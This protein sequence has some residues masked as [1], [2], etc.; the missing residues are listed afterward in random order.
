MILEFSPTIIS[1][2]LAG[3]VGSAI[4]GQIGTMKVTEQ[5]DALEIM[6]VNPPNYLILPKVIA[7]I[8]IGINHLKKRLFHYRELEA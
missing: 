8:F 1:M 2:V 7:A 3:K 6:G 5:I 4:A